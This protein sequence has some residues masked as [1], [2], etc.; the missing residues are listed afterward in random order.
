[1]YDR[2]LTDGEVADIPYYLEESG[3]QLHYDF[4]SFNDGLLEDISGNGNNG[5]MTNVTFT[6]ENIEIPSTV[7]PYRRNGKFECL[8]HQTEGLVNGK[9]VKG[10]TTARN[11]RR[12]VL[13][14]QQ[15][16]YDWQNDGMSNLTYELLGVEEIGNNSVLINCKC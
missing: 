9:W 14:M 11:E 1:M 8:P 15:G 7:I 16:K 10:E 12:Y 2:C 5:K 6:K 13:E 3:L 4:N